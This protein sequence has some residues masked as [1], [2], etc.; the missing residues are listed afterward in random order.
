MKKI[1]FNN[2][3]IIICND[4]MTADE[5]PE[6]VIMYASGS[7]SLKEA[8]MTFDSNPS[9]SRMYLPSDNIGAVYNRLCSLFTEVNAAGGLIRNPEGGV[10]VIKRNGLWDLPKGKVEQ[11]ESIEETAVREVMEECG[12]PAPQI[13]RL[14]CMTDHTYH[15]DGKFILKHTYWYAMD[16]AEK[17][18]P[19]PQTEEGITEALWIPA[20]RIVECAGNTHLSI[21]EVFRS[22]HLISE[23]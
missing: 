17:T 11:G 14:L 8:I 5:D 23:T 4:N 1:F 7:D 12:I 22:A 6:A 2:R 13:S 19:V 10:L 18:V 16:L 21:L 9:I 20:D 3:A 15:M